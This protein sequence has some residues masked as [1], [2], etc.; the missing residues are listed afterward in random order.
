M[1]FKLATLVLASL[2]I[3]APTAPI[4]ERQTTV[5]GSL[6]TILSSFQATSQGSVKIIRTFSTPA[7]L[8]RLDTHTDSPVEDSGAAAF[9]SATAAAAVAQKLIID[10]VRSISAAATA[11]AGLLT[12]EI[13]KLPVTTSEEV[14]KLSVEQRRQIAEAVVTLQTAV[15]GIQ[16]IYDIQIKDF[17]PELRQIIDDEVKL[18]Q[19]T[20][21]PLINPV[22][23]FAS[24]VVNNA[25]KAD[26]DVVGIPAA[27]AELRSV[28]DKQIAFIGLGIDLNKAFPAAPALPAAS[29]VPSVSIPAIALPSV[30]VP[31]IALPSISVPS[32]PAPS[33]SV[34]AI[35]VPSIKAP[36]VPS[37]SVPAI[38]IPKITP[39]AGLPR[40]AAV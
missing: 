15:A 21:G 20:I 14:S 6:L 8:P 25:P 39:P 38:A 34:P 4:E 9:G 12:G 19:N 24:L 10:N 36:A 17:T 11:S 30:S 2:A 23:G 27:I 3:A 18:V 28:V 33:V 35:A 32:V 13:G 22:A 16:P 7:L 1:Q 37:I 40:P 29:G 26:F 31:A 5:T